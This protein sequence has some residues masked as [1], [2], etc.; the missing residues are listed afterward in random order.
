MGIMDLLTPKS[1]E[2]INYWVEVFKEDQVSILID[3]RRTHE[4]E[5][6]HIPGA[7]SL[8]FDDIKEKH[9]E[10][11]PDKNQKI[12]IYCLVGKRSVRARAALEDLGYTNMQ[13]IGGIRDYT[14][15]L[16]K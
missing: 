2:D 6:A 14:G 16:E 3:L 11:L 15:E 4:F 8:P 10:V 5:E 9:L 7:T 13:E 1:K 12:Y